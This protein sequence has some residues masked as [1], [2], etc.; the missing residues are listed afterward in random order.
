MVKRKKLGDIF[1]IPLPNGKYAYG[2][3]Y[4]EY[5]LAIFKSWG[6]DINDFKED[7]EYVFFVGVYKNLL[8]D[9]VWPI[10]GN[11]PFADEEEAWC[12]KQ[13]IKAVISGKISLYHKGV[14][15]PSTFEECKG[16]EAV[17]AWDRHHVVDRIMGIDKWTLILK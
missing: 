9:G 4:K 7:D 10:V 8:S 5:T 16:L 12:P 17:S 14:I 2:R 13:Y 1:A 11:I 3:L 6:K 15:T